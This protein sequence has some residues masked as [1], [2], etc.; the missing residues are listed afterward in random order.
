[1]EVLG[2]YY[3]IIPVHQRNNKIQKENMTT[4]QCFNVFFNIDGVIKE[5]SSQNKIA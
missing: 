3:E 5:V 1:M 2:R 4:F